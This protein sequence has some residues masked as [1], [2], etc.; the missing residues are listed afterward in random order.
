L[1]WL[2]ILRK[3]D[4]FRRAFKAFDVDAVARFNARTVERLLLDARIVRN[5]AKIE[6]TIN[7]ARRC[8]DLVD[9][10]GGLAAYVWTFEPDPASRPR[11]LTWTTLARL[12]P[13]AEA[14]AL[15]KDLK[16]RGWSF[17]GPTTVHSFMQA[18]GMVNDHV[19]ACT[20]R[21]EVEAQ[22]IAFRP[23]LP[24]SRPAR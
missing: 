23:P 17:V 14:T 11:R 10:F 3:R 1:S 21:A 6:A 4:D 12:G 2:T 18:M 20:A 5:R 8:R 19:D 7:N 16:R 22:R 24:R 15:S 13:S 9:E